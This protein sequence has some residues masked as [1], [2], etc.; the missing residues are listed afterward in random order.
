MI[1]TS[2]LTSILH[3]PL[4]ATVGF[5]QRPYVVFNRG[6]VGVIAEEQPRHNGYAAIGMNTDHTREEVRQQFSSSRERIPEN[7]PLLL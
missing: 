6:R 5:A 1:V 7:A 4:I 2:G 3:E